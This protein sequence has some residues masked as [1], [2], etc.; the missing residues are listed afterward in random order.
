MASS[1]EIFSHYK[2]LLKKISNLSKMLRIGQMVAIW[3]GSLM[4]LLAIP[5]AIYKSVDNMPTWISLVVLFLSVFIVLFYWLIVKNTLK[6]KKAELSE[7]TSENTEII[8]LKESI[9]DTVESMRNIYRTPTSSSSSSSS[10]SN[11]SK[12]NKI[13]DINGHETGYIDNDGTVKDCYHRDQNIIVDN[14]RIYDK[15]R[16]QIGSVDSNGDFKFYW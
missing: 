4:I 2:K 1:D 9:E 15:S 11:S 14:G 3:V 7:F 8:R 13:Y 6:K 12:D 10:F 5:A 16:N